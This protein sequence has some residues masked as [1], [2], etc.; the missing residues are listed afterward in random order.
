MKTLFNIIA[1][2]CLQ[3]LLCTANADLILPA[4]PPQD[5]R[6]YVTFNF[7]EDVLLSFLDT[8]PDNKQFVM[9][10]TVSLWLPGDCEIRG[11]ASHPVLTRKLVPEKLRG[12]IPEPIG[13]VPKIDQPLIYSNAFDAIRSFGFVQSFVHTNYTASGVDISINLQ[14]NGR[15]MSIQYDKLQAT[16]ELPQGVGELLALFR[17]HLLSTYENLFDYLK[18]PTLP[19]LTGEVAHQYRRCELHNEWMQIS[20]I[21]RD[22][23]SW[24]RDRKYIEAERET[25]PNAGTYLPDPW[26]VYSGSSTMTLY[27]DSCRE[28]EQKWRENNKEEP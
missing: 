4:Y 24:C 10:N 2:I 11:T 27:C 8:K 9:C 18:V 20:D 15:S 12:D 3:A 16:D 23:G 7:S 17:R 6:L 25:F 26:L 28:A 22:F 19:P 13:F 21:P 5:W 14:V 1:C